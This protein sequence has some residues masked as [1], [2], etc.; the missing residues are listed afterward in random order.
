MG[1]HYTI[2][3]TLSVFEI[4]HNKK[5]NIDFKN[6]P[7]FYLQT[8]FDNYWSPFISEAWRSL[9]FLGFSK[10]KKLIIVMCM[11]LSTDIF[12]FYIQFLYFQSFLNHLLLLAAL[13]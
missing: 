6:S 1:D 5:F 3:Y 13:T 2:L 12:V 9:Y 11:D 7:G 4:L 8:P 10:K